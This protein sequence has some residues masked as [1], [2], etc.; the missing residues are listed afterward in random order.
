MIFCCPSDLCLK[1]LCDLWFQAARHA[2]GDK[3]L[4]IIA[5]DTDVFALLLHF[6][7]H[8][9]IN[10][11]SVYLESPV[12]GRA[13]IDIDATMRENLSII[14]S[15]LAAHALTGCDT[16]ASQYG[17]GKGIMLKILRAGILLIYMYI[18]INK[19]KIKLLFVHQ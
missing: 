18:Y 1:S 2:A 6:R 15:L 12:Q 19:H 9:S 4:I 8:G 3:A 17:I 14:P 7:Y 10:A 5:D 11:E 13:V 16:V